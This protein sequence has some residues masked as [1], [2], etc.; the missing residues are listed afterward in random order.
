MSQLWRIRLARQAE[1][2][3]HDIL[4]WTA[5]QFGAVQAGHYAETL[6]SAIE[7][8][9]AGPQVAGARERDEIASGVC[10]LHVA[11]Q[12]RKGRHLV[13]FRAAPGQVIEVLRLL[14]DGMDLVRH[15]PA[16]AGPKP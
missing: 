6:A 10:T 2:D 15:V 3:L 12:G 7:A 11:R 1:A 8:L 5:R 4:R 16:S 14:H 9:R 13:V